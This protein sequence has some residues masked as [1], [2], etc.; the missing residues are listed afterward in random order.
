MPNTLLVKISFDLDYLSINPNAI[1]LL[2]A[3]PDKIDWECL[4]MNPNAID[5]LRVNQDKIC[6][7]N[8][9]SNPAIFTYNYVQMK[10]NKSDL[11]HNLIEYLY[12]PIR[13][14]KYLDTHEDID[15]YLN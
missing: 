6:W 10:A 15:E 12:H 9:W 2:T 8:I 1:K 4:S 13:V 14:A 7:D 11:H 5:L 3:N